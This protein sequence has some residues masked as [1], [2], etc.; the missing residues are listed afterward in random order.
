MMLI[1]TCSYRKP[2]TVSAC[3]TQSVAGAVGLTPRDRLDVWV[4]AISTTSSNIQFLFRKVWAEYST[5]EVRDWLQRP[6]Q[7]DS[8]KGLAAEGNRAFWH[9]TTANGNWE[10]LV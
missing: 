5:S 1:C 8:V 2:S 4:R 6:P 9:A 3:M 7:K 10:S